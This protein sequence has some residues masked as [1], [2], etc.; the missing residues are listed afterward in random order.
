MTVR[1]A[2]LFVFVLCCCTP[3]WAG[4]IE[5]S[6]AIF[7]QAEKKA[8]AGDWNGA[9]AQY[10]EAYQA[11]PKALYVFR[12]AASYE[13]TGD[14]PKALEAYVLFNQYDPSAEEKAR[15]EAEISRIE[16]VLTRD[17]SKLFIS[18]SPEGAFVFVDEL[19]PAT[20][21][22]T[23]VTRWA[24]PGRHSIVFQADGFQPRE[25]SVELKKGETAAIY[26]GLKPKEPQR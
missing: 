19:T 10:I 2:V 8:A 15:V 26:E 4:P 21:F 20:R 24:K 1:N 14:L 5:T 7:A 16:G 6:E 23:P 12:I 22:K 18:S 11:Y 25:V 3:A 17:F 9:L 13:K